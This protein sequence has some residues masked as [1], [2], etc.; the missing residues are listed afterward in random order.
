[1]GIFDDAIRE[2]LDLKRRQGAD[3]SELSSWKTRPSAP[4]APGRPVTSR[5]PASRRSTGEAP[6]TV[7]EPVVEPSDEAP[8]HGDALLADP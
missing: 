8:P 5:R 2:H 7:D 6:A 4:G 1:M 3:E